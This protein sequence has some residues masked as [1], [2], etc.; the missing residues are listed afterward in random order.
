MLMLY[1]SLELLSYAVDPE[2][3]VH[4]I[5]ILLIA[6]AGCTNTWNLFTRKLDRKMNEVKQ[7]L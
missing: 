5:L 1:V 2:M 7:A 4:V 6:F 3:F